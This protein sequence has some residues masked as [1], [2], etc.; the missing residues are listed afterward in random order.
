VPRRIKS[1]KTRLPLSD[2]DTYPHSQ[3]RDREHLFE[4][5]GWSNGAHRCVNVNALDNAKLGGTRKRHLREVPQ[6]ERLGVQCRVGSGYCG[7]GQRT[8]RCIRMQGPFVRVGP[9]RG[10]SSCPLFAA[11]ATRRSKDVLVIRRTKHYAARKLSRPEAAFLCALDPLV[12]VDN[13]PS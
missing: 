10:I 8:E 3:N 13:A 5:V 1:C 7:C 6:P 9:D 11:C 2:R 12:S 4:I